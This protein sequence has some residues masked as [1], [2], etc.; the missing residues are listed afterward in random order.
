MRRLVAV[1]LAGCLAACGT[2]EPTAEA[3]APATATPA[4]TGT[5]SAPPPAPT[6]APTPTPPGIDAIG[7]DGFAGRWNFVAGDA[8][9]VAATGSAAGGGDVAI[10]GD[11][12]SFSSAAYG[13]EGAIDVLGALAISCDVT[14]CT[15]ATDT[16]VW[17]LVEREQGYLLES[18][19]DGLPYGVPR[20]TGCDWGPRPD[21]G[22]VEVTDTGILDG[23]PVVTAFRFAS[24]GA[25]GTGERC[26]QSLVTV[27]WTTTAT[28]LP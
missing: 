2:G 25:R 27:R 9:L 5:P 12:W 7:L 22:V 19:A 21:A 24:W 15:I 11:R 14:G 3:V 6:A 8:E 18:Q 10:D 23:R 1:V 16:P 20:N 17:R 4:V 26:S 28:R 13:A